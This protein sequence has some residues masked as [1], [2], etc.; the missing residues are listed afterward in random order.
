MVKPLSLRQFWRFN[1]D[2]AGY[3]RNRLSFGKDHDADV[4]LSP[5]SQV[6]PSHDQNALPLLSAVQNRLEESWLNCVLYIDAMVCLDA[7]LRHSVFGGRMVRL[8]S[9]LCQAVSVFLLV[10]LFRWTYN[11]ACIHF[12]WPQHCWGQFSRCPGSLISTSKGT[13]WQQEESFKS[14]R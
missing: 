2:R 4:L 6:A 1:S 10:N 13:L 7:S 8:T 3:L 11:K 5:N 14:P 12:T 9:L